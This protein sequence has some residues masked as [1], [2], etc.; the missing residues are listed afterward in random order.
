MGGAPRLSP[1][2]TLL[3]QGVSLHTAGRYVEADAVYARALKLEPRS[4]DAWQ[5][6]GLAALAR[7]DY[8][9]A[10]EYF[11]AAVKIDGS[12]EQTWFYLA[13]VLNELRQHA[14]AIAAYDKALALNPRFHEAICHRGNALLDMGRTQDAL[15]AYDGAIALKS[16]YAEAYCN[17]GNALQELN[18]LPEALAAYERTIALDASHSDAFFN[19]GS[20]LHREGRYREALA[21]YERVLGLSPQHAQAFSNRGSTLFEMKRYAEAL[22]SFDQA[23]R[24][25]PGY[26]SAYFNRGTALEKLHRLDEALA[27]YE[28]AIQLDPNSAETF[29][30]YGNALRAARR[31]TEALTAYDRAI[32]FNPNYIEAVTNRGNAFFDMK[33][34]EEASACFAAALAMNPDFP[35]AHY[36]VANLE[37]DQRKYDAAAVEFEAALRLA[38]DHEFARGNM[39]HARMHCCDWRDFDQELAQIEIGL[40]A[41]KQIVT[42]FPFQAMSQNPADLR[43]C[44]EIFA[45]E[46]YPP[47][48]PMWGG[49]RY[50]HPKIR[51]GYVAGEFREQATSYLT[52]GL[53]EHHDKNRFEIFA[54]DNGRSDDGPTR[55]RLEA[56]FDGFI[57][58]G[59]MSD[60]A[61][62]AEIRRREIDI[63]IDLNGYFGEERTGVFSYRPAPLQVNYLGFPATLGAPYF[64]YILADKI[65][66][67][68]AEEKYY[69][70]KIAW[71]PDSYQS[72]D[73]KR[74]IADSTPTRAEAGLPGDAFV[75]CCFNNSYKF[76]PQMFDVWM[77]ILQQVENSVLWILQ[78]NDAVIS[79]L[80][81]EAQARGIAGERIIFA[82]FAKLE[83][84]LARQK[85]G[86]LFLDSLPYN[87][88][89][90]AS[91]ALW[92]GLPVVTCRGSAFPGRVAASL[93][94]ALAMPEMITESWPDYE[95]LAVSL[96]KDRTRLAALR[97]KLAQ[98]RTTQPLFDTARFTRHIE[99]AFGAMHARLAAG[100]PPQSFAVD[101]LR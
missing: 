56:A 80:R 41:R 49:Q 44:S 11:S 85:L 84:H 26:A 75:F 38:P 69:A 23:I 25:V 89:T 54:F 14:Q 100:Q 68:P 36:A 66:I 24:L 64:D 78:S 55:K 45:A 37:M 3:Q 34:Y 20:I 40:R 15:V 92:T 17:R 19:R 52:V 16:D 76:T 71:L 29:N 48:A 82:P 63:L 32:A 90:T 83:Q 96:A 1:L 30:N 33:R 12:S 47:K 46:T 101:A 10:A 58:I 97:A 51:L 43:V 79:N 53:F 8:A 59:K 91:D 21:C 98:N 94:S 6:R 2:D 72:N 70:E 65:V 31:P 39:L 5:F 28:R 61:A 62:A 95:R 67:P 22:A 4:F 9:P 60:A 88:H 73:D 81:H 13:E 74:K 57:D 35:E 50:G 99:A 77:R 42:P 27:S 93:L 86:D 18:R 7:G 87:A